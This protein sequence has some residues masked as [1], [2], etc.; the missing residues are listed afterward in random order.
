MQDPSTFWNFSLKFYAQRGIADVCLDLQDR[1]GV[2]VN[3][4]L[5]LLWRAQRGG[6]LQPAEVEKVIALINDWQ[7]H[8]VQPLRG[9]RRFLK[10]P[11]TTWSSPEVASLRQ[12]I[13]EE[14]LLAERLQQDAMEA[15]F[16]PPDKLDDVRVAAIANCET[17]AR[18][19]GV[20]FGAQHLS[21]ILDRLTH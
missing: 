14:E 18:I 15:A 12:R 2:D 11:G 4:L 17:Y 13:K 7:L 1:F 21:V 19:L 10:D 3:V 16:P 5:Y 8:V 6:R 9:V 20:E